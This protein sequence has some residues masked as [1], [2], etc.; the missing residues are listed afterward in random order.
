MLVKQDGE[1]VIPYYWLTKSVK[2]PARKF[3]SN[4]HD[5]NVEKVIKQTERLIPLVMDGKMSIDNMLD[6]CGRQLS[7]AIKNYMGETQ[8][9]SPIT[10]AVKG[11]DTPLTGKTGALVNSI[12]WEVEG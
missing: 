3:L 5:L 12:T 7:T 9:N 8:A 4:G 2:I 10:T 11:S 6:E 1:G